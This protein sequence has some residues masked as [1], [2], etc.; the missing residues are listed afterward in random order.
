MYERSAIVLERYLEK[1]LKFDKTYNLKKNNENYTELIS[2]IENYQI[3][4]NKETKVIQEFDDAVAKIEG[5]QQEQ[6]RLCKTNMKLESDRVQFF[7]DLGEDAQVLDGKFKRIEVS[8][9]KNNAQ[10]KEIREEFVKQ[11]N[12]F[13]QKQKD[14]NKCDKAK[15]IGEAK[16][17]EYIKR[18]H[19]EFE[20]INIKDVVEMK[21]FITSEKEHIKQD[22]LIIMSKNGKSERVAFDQDV[23]RKA[24]NIRIDIAEKEADCYTSVYDKMKKL[25]AET[26]NETIRLNKYKKT[27]RDTS[28]KLAFLDA[29]KDYIVSF[30]DYERMTA[31]NGTK[32]HKKMMIEA[33][34]NFERDMIQ[35]RNLYEL[36]L[37]E[38]ATR[39]TKKAYKELYNKTYLRNIEDKE[40]NFEQEVNNVN[41]SM[42]T[43]INSN[44][45]RIEGIKN[46]YNVFQKEVSEKFERDLSEFRIDEEP[47]EV[48]IGQVTIQESLY[49]SINEDKKETKPKKKR[50]ILQIAQE[51]EDELEKY[52]AQESDENTH[53]TK[54]EEN[55][56]IEDYYNNEEET[57]E[58]YYDNEEDEE[59]YYDN[60]EEDQEDE[61]EYYDDDE[62]E[63]YDD[64]DE[65]DEEEYYDDEE[66]EDEE[67]Y[68]DDEEEDEEEYYDDDEEDE[69]EYYD[70][71]EEDQEEYYEEDDEEED[72][73]EYY[74]TEKYEEDDNQEHYTDF[75]LEYNNRKKK[76]E[77]QEKDQ[78]IEN[79]INTYEEDE[80][81][82]Y[83][84]YYERRRTTYNDYYDD[85]D[86]EEYENI[87]QY[88]YDEEDDEEEGK[89]KRKK[90][91]DYFDD[92]DSLDNIIANSRKKAI[93]RTT[94]KKG[95]KGILDKFF[96]KDF[97]MKLF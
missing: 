32:A 59:E 35:I 67:D 64:E 47:D 82:D 45:W 11:L 69:E 10:L 6:E 85:D 94:H 93:K 2:E 48:E 21:D 60:E 72:Q 58:D 19:T 12:D 79:Y 71:E 74:N 39:S 23:L 28:V 33:C 63:Y 54:Y 20:Q 25:L 57:Q 16:H 24:I 83:K 40:K 90:S 4:T 15:R 22:M 26:D 3:M 89:N 88:K 18:M 17:I 7:K 77:E 66:E 92:E 34:N 46:I 49:T 81:D 61:E 84:A 53:N 31:I 30:L 1:L 80:D 43:V 96:N 95:N 41:I 78:Y 8:L 50:K 76:I 27:L 29:V 65:E 37:K 73:E 52:F 51:E 9:D 13:S 68:Y 5:L 56:E 97:K 86:D 87:Y 38:A 44:Y 62:E 91:D 70:Y 14:R 55:E 75:Q 42:G 36:I